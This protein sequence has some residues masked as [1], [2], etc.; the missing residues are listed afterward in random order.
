MLHCLTDYYIAPQRD[1]SYTYKLRMHPVVKRQGIYNYWC[2]IIFFN[3]QITY[4]KIKDGPLR[5]VE[6]NS[7]HSKSSGCPFLG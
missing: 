3:Q 5:V 4:I 7:I 6:M 2:P 1:T